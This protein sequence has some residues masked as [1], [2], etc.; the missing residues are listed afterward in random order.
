MSD[1][2]FVA[3]HFIEIFG[4]AAMCEAVA[5]GKIITYAHQVEDVLKLEERI[6]LT[7]VLAMLSTKFIQNYLNF[8]L[9][10]FL[11]EVEYHL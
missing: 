3:S 11:L 10:I 4:D 2:K 7:Q 1:D 5:S 8:T 9:Q 6:S